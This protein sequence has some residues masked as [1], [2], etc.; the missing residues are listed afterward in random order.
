[1]SEQCLAKDNLFL[2]AM[3]IIA[4]KTKIKSFRMRLAAA[5]NV[6][7]CEN[8]CQTPVPVACSNNDITKSEPCPLS[9]RKRLIPMCMP[10]MSEVAQALHNLSMEVPATLHLPKHSGSKGC[11][12]RLIAIVP[13]TDR[14]RLHHNAKQWMDSTINNATTDESTS[15]DVVKALIHVPHAADP[16]ALNHVAAIALQVGHK[17]VKLESE[18]Q[19][20]MLFKAN[21]TKSQVRTLKSCLCTANT[22]SENPISGKTLHEGPIARFMGPKIPNFT[23]TQKKT[24]THGPKKAQLPHSSARVSQLRPIGWGSLGH[25]FLCI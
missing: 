6:N 9:N 17:L 11:G 7:H 19:Q 14:K 22:A 18:F 15:H 10:A 16:L 23:A 5:S 12:K 20:A 25:F 8:H 13:S 3:T 4:L 2:P 24:R 21:V 1:M